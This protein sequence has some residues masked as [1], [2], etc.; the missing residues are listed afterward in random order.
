MNYSD[1]REQLTLSFT[2]IVY[3]PVARV[4]ILVH[5]RTNNYISA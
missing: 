1:K 4:T 2:E 5:F 3:E